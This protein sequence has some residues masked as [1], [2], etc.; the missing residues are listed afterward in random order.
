MNE[1]DIEMLKDKTISLAI[2][3]YKPSER[4]ESRE[5]AIKELR[6][7][8][9]RVR[10]YEKQKKLPKCKYFSLTH[11]SQGGNWHHHIIFAAAAEVQEICAFWKKG[12]WAVQEDLPPNLKESLAC[13]FSI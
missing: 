3:T 6:K 5:A 11:L 4:P 7:Y 12:I 2:F 10:K 8:I 9:N 13:D 1:Q